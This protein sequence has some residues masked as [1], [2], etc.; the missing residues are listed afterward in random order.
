MIES[1]SEWD[2]K[3]LIPICYSSLA[4]KPWEMD[5]LTPGEVLDMYDG[6]R[7]RKKQEFEEQE[8]LFAYYITLPTHNAQRGKKDKPITLRHIF[9]EKEFARRYGKSSDKPT[10]EELY[11]DFEDVRR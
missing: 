11:K 4:L 10:K 9:G 8:H 7:V 2:R 6:L 3:Y 5:R 1:Y